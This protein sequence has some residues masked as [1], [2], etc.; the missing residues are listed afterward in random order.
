MTMFPLF[1][2]FPICLSFVALAV[3]GLVVVIAGMHKSGATPGDEPAPGEPRDHAPQ[4]QSGRPPAWVM[5]LIFVVVLLHF[6][7]LLWFWPEL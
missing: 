7:L 4:I 5:V 6:V 2:C 1:A 3:I